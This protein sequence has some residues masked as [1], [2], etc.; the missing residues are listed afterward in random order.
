M[1]GK[2][3]FFTGFI[4]SVVITFI[5]AYQF[6]QG[7]INAISMYY[8]VFLIPILISVI[9]NSLYIYAISKIENKKTKLIL[10]QIPAIILVILSLIKI[11]R[12]PQIDGSL[13][14]VAV[15]GAIA[16]GITNILWFFKILKPK[17]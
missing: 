7:D 17:H 4:L 10:S 15:V 16:L 9:P 6:E 1:K 14:F 8:V 13:N 2:I 11:P 3:V 12:V 5:F